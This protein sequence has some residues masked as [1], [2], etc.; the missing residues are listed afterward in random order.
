MREEGVRLREV[1]RGWASGVAI[2]AAEAD[3][4]RRGMT[5][6]SFTSV[7][8]E[9]PLL[10]VVLNARSETARW[11]EKAGVFGISILSRDQRQVAEVFSDPEAE[12]DRFEFGVWRPGELSVPLLE[13]AF[14][15]LEVRV[16]QNVEAGT[17]TVVVGRVEH[18]G[19]LREG[20]PIVYFD[21]A[22][23]SPAWFSPTSL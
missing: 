19:E 3:G 13:G 12:K 22:Y 6:S 15:S 7:S 21:R 5:V 9:P 8:L 14:A 1:M 2:V 23:R 16:V 4:E 20:A 18:G 10:L 17:H 11:V